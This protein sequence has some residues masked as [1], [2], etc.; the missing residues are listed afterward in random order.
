MYS[1]TTTERREPSK[2]SIQH[3]VNVVTAKIKEYKLE[4]AANEFLRNNHISL[5]SAVY[6][7]SS[8]IATVLLGVLNESLL[9]QCSQCF[10]VCHGARAPKIRP[11]KSTRSTLVTGIKQCSYRCKL[12]TR[13]V[14]QEWQIFTG[15]ITW[16]KICELISYFMLSQ[17]NV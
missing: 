10:N 14:F 15:G 3:T 8:D 2:T 7:C 11:L 12:V 4:E 5:D 9:Y 6:Y 1:K 17:S 16:Y 13:P